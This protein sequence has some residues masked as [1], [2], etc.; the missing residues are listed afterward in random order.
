M[1]GS[2]IIDIEIKIADDNGITL[3]HYVKRLNDP[4]DGTIRLEDI[5]GTGESFKELLDKY[6]SHSGRKVRDKLIPSARQY[7]EPLLTTVTLKRL[8]SKSR[9]LIHQTLSQ[10]VSKY[11]ANFQTLEED[12]LVSGRDSG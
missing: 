9:E 10:A 1:G 3:K 2:M 12:D 5:T 11:E 4:A 6:L 8:E 7:R